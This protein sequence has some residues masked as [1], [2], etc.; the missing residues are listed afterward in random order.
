[1][2]SSS[3]NIPSH[4]INQ[5]IQNF[6]Y[7][8]NEKNIELISNVQKFNCKK[9]ENLLV[10][11]HMNFI[12]SLAKKFQKS[13]RYNIEDLIQEASIGFIES[14]KKFDL[15][16]KVYLSTF[17]TY[18][19]R[20]CLLNYI[21]KNFKINNIATTKEQR[22]LFFNLPKERV[23][24]TSKW[25]TFEEVKMI[26]EKYNVST[27]DVYTMEERLFINDYSLNPVYDED[28]DTTQIDIVDFN[29]L[30]PYET[31]SN[32][33]EITYL[34]SS[35]K[36][37]LE[38]LDDREYDIISSRWLNDS[39]STLKELGEKHSLSGERINQIERNVLN[40]LRSSM[41]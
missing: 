2:A 24:L 4:F 15:S 30:D 20:A 18:H 26:A 9:S 21:V 39:K 13:S 41:N 3:F 33:K 19:I 25:F 34:N 36:K 37:S 35:L 16:K 29:N 12:I 14:I 23:N 27:D 5:N 28:E 32:D 40:K 8:T 10:K 7:L 31:I 38:S 1:M 22:K 17:A 6:E 11:S